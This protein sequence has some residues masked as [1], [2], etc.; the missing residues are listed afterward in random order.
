MEGKRDYVKDSV[1]FLERLSNPLRF[2]TRACCVLFIST[3][4]Y[5]ALP[6]MVV[7]VEILFFALSVGCTEKLVLLCS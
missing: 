7:C 1:R 5:V 4:V 2:P 6:T 3:L